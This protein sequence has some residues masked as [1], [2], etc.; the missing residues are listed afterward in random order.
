MKK[1]LIVLAD[2]YEDISSSMLNSA[3]NDLK[4]FTI[5]VEVFTKKEKIN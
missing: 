3:K 4:N 2:Y 1:I 5:K